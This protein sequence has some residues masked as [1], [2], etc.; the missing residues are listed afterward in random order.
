VPS[1]IKTDAITDAKC[2]C[3]KRTVS[4]I[5][6]GLLP[7]PNAD[8]LKQVLGVVVVAPREVPR[9]CPQPL[10]DFQQPSR[11]HLLVPREREPTFHTPLP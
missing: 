3:G 1:R 2:P 8:F 9:P 4:T 11:K 5:A 6:A 7:Q 10:L